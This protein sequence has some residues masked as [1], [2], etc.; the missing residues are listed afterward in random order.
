M[1]EV[2]GDLW[3]YLGKGIVAITTNGY[4]TRDGRAILGYGVA[5]QAGVLFPDLDKR[6]GRR[7]IDGGN[8]VHDL[9]NGLVSFPVEESPWSLPDLRLIRKSAREL[10]TMADHHGWTMVIV[11][12]PGCGGGG[13]NWSDVAPL[14]LEFFDERFHVITMDTGQ[15]NR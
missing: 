3:E 4:V 13:L 6:L 15:P 10:R 11:P 1:Q 7:L 2:A 5:R 9:G 12:R 14:L 8:Q